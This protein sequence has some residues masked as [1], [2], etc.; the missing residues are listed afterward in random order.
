[1]SGVVKKEGLAIANQ[2]FLYPEPV[3][4][5]IGTSIAKLVSQSFLTTLTKSPLTK[6]GQGV[7][8]VT[9]N[10]FPFLLF[11]PCLL[12]IAFFTG[13]GAG[14][15]SK[16]ILPL[17]RN[18]ITN[19]ENTTDTTAPSSLSISIDSGAASTTSTSVTLALSATDDVGV[20]AYCAKEASTT[21]STSDS[22]WT[23]V[24]STTSYSASVS[25]TLSSG[26][27]T[28]TVYVWFKDAA[29][30]V[31][32]SASDSITLSTTV[33]DI[34]SNVYN[35]LTIGTQV[36]FKEN[37]K[38]TKYRN[39]NI[40]TTTWAYNNTDSNV[41]TYGRLYDWY[42][43]TDSRGLCPTGWHLPTD[44][45]WTT[46]TDYLGG[47]SVAGGK[48]KEAGTT[49]WNSPNT[50]A[51]NSSSFTALPGGY[52]GSSGAFSSIGDFGDW[53]SATESSA[54]FVW[55]RYLVYNAGD[56]TSSIFHKDS[57]F[58]VRCIRD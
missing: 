24:T 1:M 8:K 21:P 53:W 9:L 52:R 49:H 5:P 20:T 27:G 37:L 47:L 18:D 54:T 3:K 41:S 17:L 35:I 13:C 11:P 25:F 4:S 50:S 44:A 40:I 14:D 29:G 39:S 28:K 36:W 33:T 51:D 38:V 32:T 2:Y 46:L 34:D 19:T 31:S 57:G 23:S 30:N 45:E 26:D 22:C 48:L 56:V 12:L 58:S 6:G 7:V 42:A 43:A 55:S 10:I 15:S 16:Y